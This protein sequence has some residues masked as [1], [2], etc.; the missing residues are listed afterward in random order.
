MTEAA[1]PLPLS[2]E[3]FYQTILPRSKVVRQ[4]AINRSSLPVPLSPNSGISSTLPRDFA[5][6]CAS[7]VHLD[8]F[9]TLSGAASIPRET[10]PGFTLP[11]FPPTISP[12]T[13]LTCDVISSDLKFAAQTMRA[14]NLSLLL[15]YKTRECKYSI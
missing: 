14:H 12:L 13:A 3:R 1:P 9:V 2:K 7:V 8:V 11:R 4:M 15:I 5:N 6:K 10:L